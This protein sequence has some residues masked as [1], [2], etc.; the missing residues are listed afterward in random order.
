[1]IEISV[2][3]N[4]TLDEV[5]EKYTSVNDIQYWAFAS[6]DWAAEGIENNLSPGGSFKNRNFAKD[7]SMEFMFSG[8]YNE[9]TPK[10]RLACTLDDGRKVEVNFK[11]NGKFVELQQLF[12]PETENPEEMQKQGWQAYLNNF[13]KHAE[14]YLPNQ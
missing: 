9:V 12:E 10:E 6:D 7:G 1:M 5:W 4:A 13:K 3:I 2:S 8:V 11:E 14:K